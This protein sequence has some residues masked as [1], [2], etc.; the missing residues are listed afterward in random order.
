MGLIS[1]STPTKRWIVEVCVDYRRLNKFT[2]HDTYP[3]LWIDNRLDALS[4]IIRQ[5]IIKILK[6]SQGSITI[7]S[8]TIAASQ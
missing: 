4:G 8:L 5:P 6:I 2:S 3:I 1:S 7:F